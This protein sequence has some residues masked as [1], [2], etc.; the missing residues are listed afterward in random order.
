MNFVLTNAV[1][2]P[3]LALIALP[4][5]LHLFARTR[6]PVYTFSSLEFI[7]RIVRLTMRIKKPQ[8]AL[9][10]AIR[11]LLV[12][13]VVL[14]FLQPVFF[15]KRRL[16][17][18]FEQKHVVVVVDATASMGSASGAQTRFASA[19]AEASE[20]LNGLSPRD[21]ANIVWLNAAPGAVFP[22][23]GA[24]VSYLLGV[25]RQARVTSEAGDIEGAM[26]LAAGLL[27][28]R[29]GHREI[30]LVSDFQ[31]SAWERAA[32]AVPAGIDV[33][34]VKVG[35]TLAANGA[36]TGLFCDPEKPLVG[37]E[38][39]LYG[40]VHNY[41]PQPVRRTVFLT[42]RESRQ[43]QDLMIPAWG[44]ATAIFRCKAAAPGPFPVSMALN[45]DAF[46][47][48]D[49][50]WAVIEVSEFL[51]VGL[52]AQEPATARE[53]RRALAALGWA[54]IETL[55]EKDLSGRLP[56]DAVLLSGW[57]GAAAENLNRKL[58]TG[59]V[60][61]CL[62]AR[63][64]PSGKLAALAGVGGAGGEAVLSWEQTAAGRG[65]KIV[66]EK[67]RVFAVFA[68]GEYGDPARGTFRGRLTIPAAALPAGET[69]IAYDDGVPALTRITPPGEGGCL[70]LWNLTLDPELSRW[71]G[72]PEFLVFFSEML[73]T[74]RSGGGTGR[75]R[76]SA[77]VLPGS[78]VV[79][80]LDP[81]AAASEVKLVKEEGGAVPATE[82]RSEAGARFVSGPI[83]EPGLYRWESQGKPLAYSAV[84]FPVVESDLRAL[85]PGEMET[86]GAVAIEGG[87]RVRE[88]RDGIKLWPYL[89]VAGLVLALMEGMVLLWAERS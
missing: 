17:Q 32:L 69:L 42:T 88:L 37:E 54:R 84:N 59:G 82:Q 5:I 16:S 4:V 19:C 77:S 15:S 31:K 72:R 53:W 10:L 58:K 45:E 21:T 65:L 60:V 34:K 23:M 48:D 22:E 71:A 50:R 52:L 27:A 46:T 1:L 44:K 86:S 33:V 57:S 78:P 9:L 12:A 25:L 41:S 13:G 38:V 24:N 28:G 3:L 20:I 56:F 80:R 11:T 76:P 30:C 73:L 7:R 51:R 63:G 75:D 67:D 68:G 66:K 18:P 79:L 40:E 85:V 6:P 36:I 35:D 55:T 70:F 83:P 62:P 2:W 43:S 29:D 49:R 64:L 26:R 8:D 61:V 81:D 87:R 74:S 89:L 14:L 39:S 47:G